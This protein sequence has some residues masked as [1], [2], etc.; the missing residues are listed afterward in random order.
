MED[1]NFFSL[2]WFGRTL[3]FPSHFFF[4]VVKSSQE[5]A[6]QGALNIGKP[7]ATIHTCYSR[8][9][10]GCLGQ[11]GT[12]MAHKALFCFIKAEWPQ[13][14]NLGTTRLEEFGKVHITTVFSL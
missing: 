5:E 4:L 7:Q 9:Y 2:L 1:T 6:Y 13:L 11:E 3:N 8:T 14:S 10:K 12:Y